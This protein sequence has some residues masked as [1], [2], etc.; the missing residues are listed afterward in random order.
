M[1]FRETVFVGVLGQHKKSLGSASSD[2][3][4]VRPYTLPHQHTVKQTGM[5]AGAHHCCPARDAADIQPANAGLVV[6]HA[7]GVR[8]AACGPD[9]ACTGMQHCHG[10][11]GCPA[12][13]VAIRAQAGS[14]RSRWAPLHCWSACNYKRTVA[15]LSCT[16]HGG[17]GG[18]EGVVDVHDFAACA[19]GQVNSCCD[20]FSVDIYE[21]FT[22][23]RVLQDFCW[24]LC[25][26]WASSCCGQEQHH[27]STG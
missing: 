25:A 5:A 18:G 2:F 21:P 27:A 16:V 6:A 3:L 7:P 14:Q 13:D 8:G 12:G 19:A 15:Q 20:S 11:I 9:K 24:A 26:G 4:F 10:N 17:G 1:S 22:C 23:A